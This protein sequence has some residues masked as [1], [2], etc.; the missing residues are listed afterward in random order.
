MKTSSPK[1]KSLSCIVTILFTML[2][3]WSCEQNDDTIYTVVDVPAQPSVAMETFRE[4]MKSM[5]KYP[6]E[7][8]ENKVEGKVYVEFVVAKNGSITDAQILKGIGN[9]CDEEALRVISNMSNWIPGE[10]N[11]KPVN[12]RLVLPIQFQLLE[13]NWQ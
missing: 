4:Q 13:E 1:L 2:S 5:L 10:K 3:L 12:M 9:G 7:A 6:T 8:K 11:G